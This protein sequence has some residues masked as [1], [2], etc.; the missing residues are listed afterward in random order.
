M[1][2]HW[3]PYCNT[4]CTASFK[5]SAGSRSDPLTPTAADHAGPRQC[6]QGRDE[7]GP[8]RGQGERLSGVWWEPQPKEES[9]SFMAFYLWTGGYG[10]YHVVLRGAATRKRYEGEQY[11]M[12]RRSLLCVNC[13]YLQTSTLSTSCYFTLLLLFVVV[14]DVLLDVGK[15]QP[16]PAWVPFPVKFRQRRGGGVY[17]A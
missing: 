15:P 7:H 16:V 3:S 14:M 10:D 17:A 2:L 12:G 1:F 13:S 11:P 8:S 6:P 5:R 9:Y 4:I